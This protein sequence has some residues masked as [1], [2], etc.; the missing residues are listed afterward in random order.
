MDIKYFSDLWNNSKRFYTIEEKIW[1]ERAEEF[2]GKD[3]QEKEIR[4]FPSILEFIEVAQDKKFKNVLDIGCGTGFYSVQFSEIS[5]HVTAM[6]ISQNMLDYAEENSKAKHR[7]NIDFLKKTWSELHLED[8][9]WEEKFDLVF[10]SM[11]PAID[12]YENLIKMI[13]CGRKLYFLS[14]FVEKKHSLKD[15]LSKIILSSHSDSPYGSKIY[16]AFNILWNMGYYPKIS[17]KDSS[18]KK[19]KSIDEFYEEVLIYFGRTKTLTE[20]DKV[21]IKNYIENKAVDGMIEEKITAKV[22][23]LYWKK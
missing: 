11:S 8:L 21:V 7:N 4:N 2:N 23:W 15:E 18:W 13:N 19:C 17:Y 6:D 12:S 10:A 9:K 5:E 14:G 3:I 1:D 22:A 16:S 20:E